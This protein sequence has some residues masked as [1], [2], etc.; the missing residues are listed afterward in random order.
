MVKDFYCQRY[1]TLKV[2]PDLTQSEKVEN[3]VAAPPDGRLW[4]NCGSV[5]SVTA[6]LMW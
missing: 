4:F 3:T 6:A 5:M 2:N 1:C